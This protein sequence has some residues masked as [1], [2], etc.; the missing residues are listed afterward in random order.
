MRELSGEAVERRFDCCALVPGDD[1][2]R[3][4]PRGE[5]RLGRM[6]HERLAGERRDKLGR[7]PARLSEPRRGPGGEQDRRRRQPSPSRGCG[8]EAISM[9]SPPTPMPMMSAR[10]DRHVGEDALQDPVE[11]VLLAA[12]ARSPARR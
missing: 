2:D 10:G 12:S 9:R 11:A 1:D 8:R 4:R 6:T 3:T 7:A 5:R